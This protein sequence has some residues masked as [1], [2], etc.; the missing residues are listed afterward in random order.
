[1]KIRSGCS[2][3]ALQAVHAQADLV[4]RHALGQIPRDDARVAAAHVAPPSSVSHTPAAEMPTASRPG[5]RAR[6]RSSAGRA[7]RRRAATSAWWGASIAR[8]WLPARA[9]VAALEQHTRVPA[10]VEHA[11]GLGG[12]DHPDT[13]EH[14]VAPGQR[15]AGRLLPVSCEI[16][17]VEDLRAVEGRCD[18][19][20]HASRARVAECVLDRVTRE[21]P[22]RHLE[23]RARLPLEH[24]QALPRPDE[25][26]GDRGGILRASLPG[27]AVVPWERLARIGAKSLAVTRLR[28]GWS[29]RLALRPTIL[30]RERFY[31][32]T[33]LARRGNA[34]LRPTGST[35]GP[36]PFLSGAAAGPG[37]G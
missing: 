19:R 32:D 33:R 36:V 14:G 29:S 17:R 31:A 26:L 12:H 2:R 9:A 35:V 7:R 18:R 27:L 10:G 13:L 15:D 37:G 21:R 11:V 16:V 3:R 23:R 1:M 25:Q 4:L 30:A 5:S 28:V 20:M 22:R 6:S 24:E 34:P 8:G